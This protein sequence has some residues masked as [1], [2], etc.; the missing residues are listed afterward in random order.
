MSAAQVDDERHE[1]KIKRT[2]YEEL[3]KP[4]AHKITIDLPTSKGVLTL[5][6]DPLPIGFYQEIE[7]K[8]PAPVPSISGYARDNKG[9]FIR[10]EK[11][12]PVPERDETNPKYLEEKERHENRVNT[13][14]IHTVL[15]SCQEIEFSADE[16]LLAGEFYDAIHAE[17]LAAG[18]TT[19]QFLSVVRAINKANDIDDDDMREAKKN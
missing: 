4:L 6:C 1:M 14:L 10:D 15:K 19:G 3:E 18:M 17:L 13:A 11:G 8:L 7:R 9:K 2:G 16:K 12:A 5:E